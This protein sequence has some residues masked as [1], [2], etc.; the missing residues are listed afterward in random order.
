MSEYIEKGHTFQDPK[1]TSSNKTPEN[2]RYLI[3]NDIKAAHAH[4]EGTGTSKCLAC[5]LY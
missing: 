2:K 4:I 1:V 3:Y 5:M